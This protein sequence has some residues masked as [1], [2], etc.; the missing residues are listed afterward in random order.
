MKMNVFPALRSWVLRLMLILL[1]GSLL[2]LCWRFGEQRGRSRTRL[3]HQAGTAP[4]MPQPPEESAVPESASGQ[5]PVTPAS[6]AA[7]LETTLQRIKLTPQGAGFLTRL[8]EARL[9][10]ELS[11]TGTPQ[12]QALVEALLEEGSRDAEEMAG[13]ILGPVLLARDPASVW[14]WIRDGAGTGSAARIRFLSGTGGVFEAW[15]KR[16]PAAALAAWH[17]EARPLVAAGKLEG[18][19]FESIFKSWAASRPAAALEA[20]EQLTDP[21]LRKSAAEGLGASLGTLFGNAPPTWPEDAEAT[22]NRILA[23]SGEKAPEGL[24]ALVKGRLSHETP[25][26]AAAWADQL[27]MSP[28]QKILFSK[29]LADSWMETDPAAA[30]GWY[31]SRLPAGD[32]AARSQAL[33]RSIR[34]WTQVDDNARLREIAAAAHTPPDLAAA[35]EWLIAQGLGTSSQGAMTALARAWGQAREPEAAVAWARA[36]PDEAVRAQAM[37]AVTEEIRQRFPNDWPRLTQP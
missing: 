30:A 15:A 11:E 36:L 35:S 34:K 32:S 37:A 4:G 8:A 27:R 7:L 17:T 33:E 10:R 29:T 2:V 13:R 16:D 19:G 20:A 18:K 1:A 9:I 26:E 5:D 22:I 6:T 12:L 14:A 23:F 31:L 25:V 28:E 24:K 3:I 21:A